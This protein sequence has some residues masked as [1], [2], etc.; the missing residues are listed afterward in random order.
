MDEFDAISVGSIRASVLLV[1]D[2]PSNLL[3]LQAVL[4]PLGVRIVPAQ[5]GRE[6]LEC[7]AREPFAVALVDV[8]MP[9]M[10]GF[11]VLDRVA[12]TWLPIVVFVTAHDRFALKAFET[13]ALDY[14]LKPFTRDR[15]RAALQRARTAFASAGDSS[16]HR[17]IV[18]LLNDRSRSP[19]DEAQGYLVR[20]AVK[21]HRGMRLVRV[22]D[23]D[24]IEA[25]GNYA[26]IHAGDRTHLVRMTMQELEQ[27]LDPS[28][29]V[30]IQ[31]STI[32]QIDRIRDIMSANHGDFDL[33][34][35]DG[36]VLRLSRNY[37]SRLQR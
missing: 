31:R 19:A 24:Y 20:F 21:H 37:R 23:V 16:A 32:V 36:T 10:D 35:H 17:G 28:M 34:L 12:S 27:R 29:F 22:R 6:A 13:H 25:C 15:F 5:S 26:E 30:R 33:S 11:E 14:L 7:V 1:D 4:S 18:T 9:G 8:Q 2:T 3:A